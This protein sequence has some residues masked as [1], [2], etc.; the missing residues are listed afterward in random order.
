MDKNSIGKADEAFKIGE[1]GTIIRIN[2]QESYVVATAFE[3]DFK[4]AMQQVFDK[5]ALS[6]DIFFQDYSF[7]CC[8][9]QNYSPI[10]PY[11]V[12][13]ISNTDSGDIENK[14]IFYNLKYLGFE[15]GDSMGL[16][17]DFPVKYTVDQIVSEMTMIFKTIFFL[18]LN[19]GIIQ[20]S[21]YDVI[22]TPQNITSQNRNYT[23]SIYR[24]AKYSLSANPF[25]IFID[26]N[27]VAYVPNG[28][29]VEIMVSEGMHHI[30]VVCRTRKKEFNI[31]IKQDISILLELKGF[32]DHLNYTVL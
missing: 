14:K 30:K 23:M 22:D 16:T 21:K 10:E 2:E 15:A 4:N 31:D 32:F 25:E 8:G 17:K 6:V 29:K 19:S 7:M 1:D 12:Q 18:D 13:V 28:Q 24:K 11:W 27:L 26:N 20:I 3:S 9:G 5:E